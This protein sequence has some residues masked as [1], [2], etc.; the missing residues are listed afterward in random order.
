M[1]F[2]S[3]SIGSSAISST[4]GGFGTSSPFRLRLRIE[5]RSKRKPS[6]W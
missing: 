6:M 5:A 1:I 3:A 4:S 2:V